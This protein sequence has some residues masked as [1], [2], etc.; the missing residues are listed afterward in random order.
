MS[1]G[2]LKSNTIGGLQITLELFRFLDFEFSDLISF[3][4]ED[5]NILVKLLSFVFLDD[6]TE[7]F[8]SFIDFDFDLDLD[9]GLNFGFGFGFDLAFGLDLGFAVFGL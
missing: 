8:L 7:A 2:S 3:I 9:F 1:L 6:K 4:V 5:L